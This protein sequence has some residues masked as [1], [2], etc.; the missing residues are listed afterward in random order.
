MLCPLIIL[1]HHIFYTLQY[2]HPNRI[3]RF[4]NPSKSTWCP[5]ASQID[6]NCLSDFVIQSAA[7]SYNPW[8][9]FQTTFSKQLVKRLCHYPHFSGMLRRVW[10]SVL[11]FFYRC[12][13][14][15]LRSHITPC[16]A[17]EYPAAEK[18]SEG[19]REACPP[20][21]TREG[22][23][24]SWKTPATLLTRSLPFCPRAGGCR[25]SS[26]ESTSLRNSFFFPLL[27]ND[28]RICWCSVVLLSSAAWLNAGHQ[29]ISNHWMCVINPK[30]SS[31]GFIF[32]VMR[33][34]YCT[35]L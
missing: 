34:V 21:R 13:G 10:S 11:D 30:F 27:L 32:R 31:T 16:S 29:E 33:G 18:G 20:P 8:L 6:R 2:F 23:P 14:C 26:A 17:A 9:L 25:A 15:S 28:F 1:C 7:V 5:A 22:L 24:R 4:Q 35:P 19:C 3:S 12:A